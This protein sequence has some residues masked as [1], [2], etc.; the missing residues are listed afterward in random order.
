MK[1]KYEKMVHEA[2]EKIYNKLDGDEN[3]S[4]KEKCDFATRFKFDNKEKVKKFLLENS[5][6]KDRFSDNMDSRESIM[7]FKD[8]YNS[9][10]FDNNPR[11][12]KNYKKVWDKNLGKCLNKHLGKSFCYNNY[13]DSSNTYLKFETLNGNDRTGYCKVKFNGK[14][15]AVN[16]ES[17]FYRNFFINNK[18]ECDKDLESEW[19]EK[20]G[21]DNK[22]H[23]YY[24]NV[25]WYK[26]KCVKVNISKLLLP[27]KMKK[28]E[29][30]DWTYQWNNQTGKCK[31]SK[32]DWKCDK[33]ECDW[34]E[35]KCSSNNETTIEEPDM[36]CNGEWNVK[37]GYC[38]SQGK[39]VGDTLVSME[40][41][42]CFKN[43][44]NEIDCYKNSMWNKWT[45]KKSY[46]VIPSINNKNDCFDEIESKNILKLAQYNKLNY[47]T[48]SNVNAIDNNVFND[49]EEYHY[50]KLEDEL[51]KDD[52]SNLTEDEKMDYTIN[53]KY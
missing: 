13:D 34:K 46:C 4:I 10:C 22:K 11:L 40:N 43:I 16:S 31:K 38:S 33:E 1:D 24:R 50:S 25:Y 52:Y 20:E 29:C 30:I 14:Q 17:C 47:R 45:K 39:V 35:F 3:M 5:C 32:C 8:Y 18:D 37:R 36:T 15:N 41:G 28:D 23:C 44:T 7:K 27:D 21:D 6:L 2:I 19:V 26:N 51:E 12:I 49:N 53:K 9:N 42:K 48:E